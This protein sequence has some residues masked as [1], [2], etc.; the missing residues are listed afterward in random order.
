[1]SDTSGISP[2]SGM[3]AVAI[4]C[5]PEE[6]TDSRV[7]RF[8]ENQLIQKGYSV[9]VDRESKT[10]IEWAKGVAEKLKSAQAVVPLERLSQVTKH[11]SI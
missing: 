1:M 10:S 9:N 4:I 11:K 8:L 2:V 5:R 3:M 7:A 6:E